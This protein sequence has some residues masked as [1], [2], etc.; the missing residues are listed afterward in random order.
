MSTTTAPAALW[1]RRPAGVRAA[2]WLRTVDHK[3]IGV[4]YMTM[5][6]VFL[7]FGG[8]EALA[9]R[10]QL[11]TPENRLIDP[12]AY[13]QLFTIHGVTMI[14]LV[15]IPVLV[16]FMNYLVPL[17]I[18]ARDV[19]FPRLNAL[20]FWLSLLGGVLV[21][22]SF[23]AGGG[24][25]AGWFA[26]PPLSDRTYSTGPG[27]DYYI[28]GLAVNG[29]GTIVGAINIAVTILLMRAPGLSI[30][31]LPLFVWM[32]LVTS[33]LILVAYPALSAALVML[34]ADRRL[35]AHFFDPSTGGEPLIWQHVFW[36]FGHP[37]VYI[38]ILPAFGMISE[39]IPVFSGKPIFG[40][41]FIAG[42]SVAIGFL[43]VSVWAHHMFAVGLS[44]A[45]NIF[46]S[47]AS[48]L[49]AVPT[50]VKVLN[51]TATMIGGRLRF[52]TAML[53]AVGF[54]GTFVMGGL[55]GVTLA[56]VPIDWY[57]TDSYYVVAHMHYVLFGGVVFGVF[58]GLYYWFPKM[59][60]RLMSERLG[61]L[62]F[63][64]TFVGFHMTFLPQHWLGIAG[65][66]R[67]IF[68]YAADTGWG[69]LNLLSSVGAGIMTIGTLFF[70]WNLLVSLRAGAPAGDDP[71]DAWTLEWATS[72][73]P[74]PENFPVI[75][76]VT[77]KRPLWDRKHPDR[78]DEA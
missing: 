64:L 47:A 67:R 46:F 21:Y 8:V 45:E 76:T 25:D 61:K 70:V 34:F 28:I 50:G 72:S 69:P 74:P 10:L 49:I 43:S 9:I 23:V 51:W 32:T 7:V 71:W 19:A 14:F 59:T 20:S 56:I 73:P 13:N 16:G 35:G 62:H 22:F 44:E 17:M 26:Y 63:W 57:V 15:A 40:Y 53:W 48:M 27:M 3:E 1:V 78:M 58:A 36:F 5:A 75:P 41:R 42:S 77:S 30:S 31:R 6:L 39:V 11:A 18:G 24:P 4:L 54:I 38:V 52:T 29:A 37:E 33:V 2:G 60:G 68:T 55:T 65:M 12:Q 66:P